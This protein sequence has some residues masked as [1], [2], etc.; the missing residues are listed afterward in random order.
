[1]RKVYRVEKLLNKLSF[2]CT[3]KFEQIKSSPLTF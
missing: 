2:V 3:K 1:M